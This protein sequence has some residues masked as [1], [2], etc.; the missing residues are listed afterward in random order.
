MRG[1]FSGA[2]FFRGNGGGLDKGCSG[3]G[4]RW[5][6]CSKI[7]IFYRHFVDLWASFPY[8]DGVLFRRR[9]MSGF[10]LG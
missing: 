1:A 10:F 7:V 9:T 8:F 6:R 5:G 4:E 2:A 3:A